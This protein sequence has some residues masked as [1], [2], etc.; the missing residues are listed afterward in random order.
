VAVSSPTSTVDVG[1]DA[2]DGTAHV[3]GIEG[4]VLSID[5]SNKPPSKLT[6]TPSVISSA[7]NSQGLRPLRS[8]SGDADDVCQQQAAFGHQRVRA[9][10]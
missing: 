9:G 10:P 2:K 5:C 1:L 8:V 6:A 4:S 7:D 3:L